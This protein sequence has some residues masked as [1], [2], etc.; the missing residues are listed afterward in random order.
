MRPTALLLNRATATPPPLPTRPP[1]ARRVGRRRGLLAAAVVVNQLAYGAVYSWSIL[2]A[3]LQSPTGGFALGR[4]EAGLPFA[5][6]HA[7]VF[8]GTVLGG[9]LLTVRQRPDGTPG[10]RSRQSPRRIAALAG[11]LY[12]GGYL[13]AGCA[14]GRSD[15]WLVLLG[16]GGISGVG[17]GLGYIVP[18]TMLQRWFPGHRALAAGVATGGFGLG[19]VLSAPLFRLLV[20]HF[21]ADPARVL[22]VLGAVF[23]VTTLGGAAF[24]GDPPVLAALP[25]QSGAAGLRPAQALRTRHWYLLTLILFCNTAAGISMLSVV[26]P[27][28]GSLTGLGP[29]M[30]AV[31]TGVLGVF[32]TVGRPLWGWLSGRTGLLNAFVLMLLAQ[33]IGLLALSQARSPWLFLAVAAL[34][35]LCFGG[36]FA[37]MPAVVSEFFGLA[38]AG[39]VYGLMLIGWGMAGL[40]GPL[41]VAWLAARYS[42]SAAFLVLGAATVAAALLPRLTGRPQRG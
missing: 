39:A 33:G 13:L 17:L 41:T 29:A 37:T 38:H 42:Y 14:H 30:A 32:N 2:S 28:A 24:F 19:S 9:L 21:A 5:T 12:A 16:Y 10:T 3:G 36:G 34:I 18:T 27:A 11:L 35:C 1:L 26:A 23:L 40:A 22:L 15:F 7:V 31:L 4:D 8:I 6:A 25:A 20:A